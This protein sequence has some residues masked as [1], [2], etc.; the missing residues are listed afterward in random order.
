MR[1]QPSF[2][3]RNNNCF[4]VFLE[5]T[6]IVTKFTGSMTQVPVSEGIKA[7]PE[8]TSGYCWAAGPFASWP[9]RAPIALCCHQCDS[10]SLDM[11]VHA[12]HAKSPVCPT[13]CNPMHCGLPGSS[14]RGILQA[15][16]LEWVVMPSSRG[17]SWPRDQTHIAYISCFGRQVLYQKY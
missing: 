14:V 3:G 7:G 6:I 10:L 11:S 4:V 2:F 8:H 16:I 1:L 9:V 15:R 17:S 12:M 13:L 5:K